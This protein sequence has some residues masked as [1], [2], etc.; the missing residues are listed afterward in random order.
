[1]IRN[2]A[3]QPTGAAYVV[4]KD[5]DGAK[6]ALENDDKFDDNELQKQ[7]KADRDREQKEK[8]AAERRKSSDNS[9]NKND[10]AETKAAKYTPGCIV[11]VEGLGLIEDRAQLQKAF[12][13]FGDVAYVDYGNDD[14]EG[15]VRF[16]DPDAVQNLLDAYADGKREL[17][18]KV[19]QLSLLEGE[20]EEKY[21]QSIIER[22][23]AKK[24]RK[25]SRGRG[26]R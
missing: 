5:V 18:G 25:N 6:K 15:L 23:S 4:F 13:P 9:N 12:E 26:R 3:H 11:K 21:W 20:E 22:S 14:V 10:T 2:K 1:M 8:R 19:P 16:T 17:L 7:L 24:G